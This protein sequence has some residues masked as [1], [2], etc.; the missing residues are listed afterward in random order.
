MLTK[1]TI[2][3]IACL[4][5]ASIVSGQD[6]VM[7]V[8]TPYITGQILT[9]RNTS[10]VS[11]TLLGDDYTPSEAAAK[12]SLYLI[13]REGAIILESSSLTYNCHG[14]AWSVVEGGSIVVLGGNPG[15]LDPY[16]DDYSYV[17]TQDTNLATKIVY[18]VDSF[19]DYIEH[20]AIC[21]KDPDTVISKWGYD[22]PL[23]K[24]HIENCQ[25]KGSGYTLRYYKLNPGM[26]VGSETVCDQESFEIDSI[27][28]TTKFNWTASSKLNIVS[29]SNWTT[30]V[31]EPSSSTVYGDDEYLQAVISTVYDNIDE[32]EDVVIIIDTLRK[33]GILVSNPPSNVQIHVP[34]EPI[35]GEVEAMV[36]ASSDPGEESYDWQLIRRYDNF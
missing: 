2:C 14:N 11:Y 6:T 16:W 27:T 15:N 19:P 29:G 33:E 8:N 18:Q 23:V 13:N 31:V 17:P 7:L 3:I 21:T 22:G 35:Y 4:N 30:L 1:I 26:I 20:S 32:G 9:P 34:V 25:W 10:I 24:H 36:W 5:L 12:D 28:N